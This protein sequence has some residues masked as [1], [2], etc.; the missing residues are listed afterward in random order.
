MEL[1]SV[2]IPNYN[3]EKYISKCIESVLQQ[4]YSNIEI[5]VVDDGSSDASR[6]IVQKYCTEN[7][8]IKLYRQQNMNASIA[9]NKGID[10]SSGKYLFFLD[11]DDVLYCDAIKNMVDRIE[12]DNSQ[13]VIAN[14]NKIDIND[15]KIEQCNAVKEAQVITNVM[16]L[17]GSTPNPSN[18]L[19]LS[20]IVKRENIYFGNVRIGQ[21]LNFYLKYLCFCNKVST[22]CESVYGWRVVTGSISNSYNFRIFDIVE[23]FKDVKQFYIFKGKQEIYDK[24]IKIHEYRHCYLQMEK[25]KNFT[26]KKARRIVVDYFSLL[27]KN[28]D[29]SCCENYDDYY[30]DVKKCK[31][32]LKLKL[33]Y[34]SNIYGWCDMQIKKRKRTH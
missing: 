17:S 9:R 28:Y 20:E 22:M 31:W 34:C 10:I 1:V 29:L 7:R 33:L 18:K 4:T 19:F 21:D 2:I 15:K 13:L 3:A 11:S 5:I 30:S 16:M 12:K 8:D 25:Q 23:S 26:N 6:E 27:L 14:F 32:K 24:Y